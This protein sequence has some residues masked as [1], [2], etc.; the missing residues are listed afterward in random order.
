MCKTSFVQHARNAKNGQYVSMTYAK[1]H[2]NTLVVERD[3]VKIEMTLFRFFFTTRIR[4]S[5]SQPGL[6]MFHNSQSTSLI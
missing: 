6:Y 2:P 5:S 1:K 4:E 3:K